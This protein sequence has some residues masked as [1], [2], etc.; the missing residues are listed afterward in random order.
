MK[1]DRLGGEHRLQEAAVLGQFAQQGEIG[2]VADGENIRLWRMRRLLPEIFFFYSP[3]CEQFLVFARR[4][5]PY[6][7]WNLL[8]PS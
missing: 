8:N 3:V 4:E 7:M 5:V 6:T 2:I 1:I